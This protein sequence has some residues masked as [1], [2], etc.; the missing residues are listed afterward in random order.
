VEHVIRRY[1]FNLGVAFMATAQIDIHRSTLP[2]IRN[3]PA[4]HVFAG[5]AFRVR[6]GAVAPPLLTTGN[7]NGFPFPSNIFVHTATN[8]PGVV[9]VDVRFAVPGAISDGSNFVAQFQLYQDDLGIEL[10]RQP[11]TIEAYSDSGS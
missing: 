11:L 4:N 3:Q 7:W 8:D 6:T 1:S 9:T 10:T 5:F 2:S